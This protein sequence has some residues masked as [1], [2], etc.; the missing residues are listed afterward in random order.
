[1]AWAKTTILH[2]VKWQYLM[3]DEGDDLNT[4]S[5]LQEDTAPAPSLPDSWAE[6]CVPVIRISNHLQVTR[7]CL[8]NL[9]LDKSHVSFHPTEIYSVC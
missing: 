7:F 3:H 4:T 8:R 5:L 2:L 1:M 6:G 9:P